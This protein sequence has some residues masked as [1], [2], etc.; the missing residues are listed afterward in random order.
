MS[1]KKF[2][3]LLKELV[4]MLED[5]ESDFI[6][7]IEEAGSKL[8]EPVCREKA[9]VD[10]SERSDDYIIG[11]YAVECDNALGTLETM[12]RYSYIANSVYGDVDDNDP[13]N[14]LLSMIENLRTDFYNDGDEA[15]E[16]FT[17]LVK[18]LL[19]PVCNPKIKIL[20]YDVEEPDIIVACNKKKYYI[21]LVVYDKD[22]VFD[23]EL[24]DKEEKKE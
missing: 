8:I 10:A 15:I 16:Q 17:E 22:R 24:F 14:I 2:V 23:A 9:R 20:D 3:E 13:I 5:V 18:K 21:T 4:K 7:Y 1:N 11:H 6:D 12:I 19:K